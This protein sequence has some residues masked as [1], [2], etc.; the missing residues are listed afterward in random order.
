MSGFHTLAAF[1]KCRVYIKCTIVKYS[2]CK[3]AL[4]QILYSL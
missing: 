3:P 2:V 1:I 4:L